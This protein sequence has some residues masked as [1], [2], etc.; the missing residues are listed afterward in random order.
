MTVDVLM[1]CIEHGRM[2]CWAQRRFWLKDFS[3]ICSLNC[4]TLICS[5]SS[6]YCKVTFYLSY[7]TQCFCIFLC[8]T[9]SIWIIKRQTHSVLWCCLMGGRKG[10]W[11]VKKWIVRCLHCYLSGTSADL[12]IAKLM[13]LPL[14]LS[15][16]S[17]S[18]LVLPVWYQAHRSSP[19][20][21][22]IKWVFW[23]LWNLWLMYRWHT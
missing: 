23:I 21:G 7:C 5:S 9:R 12:H 4:H 16:S 18:R 20:Q 1:L 3:L 6:D 2:S 8:T 11:H 22:A 19:R 13:P 10:I 14:T 17:K 15:C